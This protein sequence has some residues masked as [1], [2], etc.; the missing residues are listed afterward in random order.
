MKRAISSILPLFV[1]SGFM[2]SATPVC[3]LEKSEGGIWV[4]NTPSGIT[5]TNDINVAMQTLE[6][7]CGVTTGGTNP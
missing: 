3:T 7:E 2:W 6:S 4:V 5:L 1:A